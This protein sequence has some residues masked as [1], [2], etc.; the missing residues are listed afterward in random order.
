MLTVDDIKKL[1]DSFSAV[2]ATKEES[3]ELRE[4]MNSRFRDVT[5]K[6]DAVFKEVK[7]TRQEQAFHT[8]VHEDIVLEQTKIKKRISIIEKN[9]SSP[10]HA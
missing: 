9:L 10:S 8:Q 6:L 5:T 3:R 4:E 2:F 7:D 1:L